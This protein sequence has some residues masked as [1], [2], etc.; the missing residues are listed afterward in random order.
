MSNASNKSFTIPLEIK[1]WEQSDTVGHKQTMLTLPHATQL[2]ATL[3]YL[4]LS[5]CATL[6]IWPELMLIGATIK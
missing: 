1:S 3:K 4:R 5:L 6:T 2:E